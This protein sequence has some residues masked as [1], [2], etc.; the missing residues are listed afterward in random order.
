MIRI[1]GLGLLALI[2]F[3]LERR[4]YEKMWNRSL[5]VSIAFSQQ[6]IREGEEGELME[7]IENRKRLPLAILKV[8]FQTDRHLLFGDTKG[9]RT[10]DKFYRNDVF[11]AGGGERITRHLKFVGGKRG[12]YTIE[13]VDLVASDLFLTTQLVESRK[14]KNAVYV[15][16]RLFDS[17]EFRLSLE[18]LNGEVTARRH[19]LTDPFTYKG[20][21]EYQ[22]FDDMKSINWK[23][24]AKTGELKVNQR[25]YTALKSVRVFFN[26]EDN[27]I[28]KKEECV[29][30]SFQIAAGLCAYFL[31][32]GIQVACYGNGADI[33]TRE[34]VCIMPKAGS[35]QFETIC[36]ALARVDTS[37]PA[38]D[39]CS[40]FEEL[41]TMQSQ[42]TITCFISPNHY[43]NF[44]SL[45]EKYHDMGKEY[46][47]FYPVPE[48]RLEEFKEGKSKEAYFPERIRKH[49]SFLPISLS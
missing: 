13:N 27:N 33:L 25:G 35:G 26:I 17:R 20:I 9:S 5:F 38:L 1:I 24:T 46:I 8:K 42:S 48:Y 49:I 19:L 15:Y 34:P 43:E 3:W 36:R 14:T 31:K 2:L 44:L 29:E 47:W 6:S 12:Y 21:R 16:P 30:A 28:M 10:T 22:P 7:I 4:I 45:V 40:L 18:M 11:R 37:R 23:A 41:L 39:F 32:Q